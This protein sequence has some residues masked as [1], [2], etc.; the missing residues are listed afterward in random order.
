MGDNDIK[1]QEYRDYMTSRPNK[2]VVLKDLFVAVE[3]EISVRQRINMLLSKAEPLT[4]V[5][6]G[7]AT[8]EN[9]DTIFRAIEPRKNKSD[10][11]IVLDVDEKTAQQHQTFAKNINKTQINVLQGDMR[12]IPL[13]SDSTDLVICDMTINYNKTTIENEVAIGEVRRICKPQR[14]GGVIF[15]PVVDAKYD[16]PMY[17]TNQENV[18][19]DA[20]N[21]PGE[22]NALP[23]GSL[24]R[25]C[26]PLPYY[27]QLLGKNFMDIIEFDIEEGKQRFS[28]PN[29]KVS[30][31]RF[32]LTKE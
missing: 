31:R 6:V 12:A 5:I 20:I 1:E 4:I 7:S 21:T 2:K 16:E 28:E 15:S 9:I 30:Y 11:I 26:W 18:P 14:S 17:G 27:R 22:F 25:L 24:K 29:N 19:A 10:R 23:D 32:W 8:P 13:P 3:K